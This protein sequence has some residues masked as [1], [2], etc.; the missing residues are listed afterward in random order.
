M[1]TDRTLCVDTALPASLRGGAIISA[2][3]AAALR[4]YCA[5]QLWQERAEQRAALARLS[6]RMLKDIGIS[7]AAANREVSKPF[8]RP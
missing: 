8:W 4:A 7:R 1:N 6:D 5:V 2:L 3:A